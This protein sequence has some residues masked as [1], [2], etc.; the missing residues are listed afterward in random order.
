MLALPLL[1]PA[2]LDAG[3]FGSGGCCD[4]DDD[5]DDDG[6]DAAGGGAGLG[7]AD[8]AVAA[9]GNVGLDGAMGGAT[10][11]GLE[12][13]LGP[14]ELAADVAVAAA[15]GKRGLAVGGAGG[16]RDEG[17]AATDTACMGGI[18]GM[19]VD[20]GGI[21]AAAEAVDMGT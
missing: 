9:A 18:D 10:M 20:I 6:A 19:A 16:G 2:A 12:K 1:P 4:D 11:S 14:G 3:G 15:L 7:G 17:V 21:L 13:P 5:A 8:A